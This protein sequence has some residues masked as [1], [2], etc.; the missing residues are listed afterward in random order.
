[1][2]EAWLFGASGH[3]FVINIHDQLCPSGPTAWNTRRM[4]ELS[5]NVGC[6]L[7]VLFARKSSEDFEKQRERVWKRAEAEGI[8]V[9]KKIATEL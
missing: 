8:K 1:M 3:A 9:L 6:D 4:S 7:E 2:S 5:E